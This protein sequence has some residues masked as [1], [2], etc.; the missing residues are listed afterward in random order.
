MWLCTCPGGKYLATQEGVEPQLYADNLKC[1]LRDPGVLLRA[2]R[3]TTGYVRFV[4]QEPAPR[5]CVLRSTSKVARERHSR[6]FVVKVLGGLWQLEVRDPGGH[7]DG[8]Q[9][10]LL[11]SDCFSLMVF[12]F[13]LPLDFHLRLWVV[14]SMF[15]PGA[16]RG[17]EASYLAV[18]S[19]RK[20]RSSIF[21]VA[22]SRRQ[23]M[24][25]V[26]AVLSLLD[27]PQGCDPAYCVVQVPYD[28]DVS[29]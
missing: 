20:L 26:G 4:G 6:L 24:A 15:I 22:W 9:P 5:K 27:G 11:E 1:V 19:L 17:I 21:S 2:A 10:W 28:S 18:R 13:V 14:R 8:L 16:L 3:F 23:P 12:I 29:R 25:N 7:P